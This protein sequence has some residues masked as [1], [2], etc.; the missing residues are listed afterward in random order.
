MTHSRQRRA[1]GPVAQ[2]PGLATRRRAPEQGAAVL[3]IVEGDDG[4]HG[5]AVGGHDGGGLLAGEGGSGLAGGEA[6]LIGARAVIQRSLVGP[7][8]GL[9]LR[10]LECVTLDHYPLHSRA[11]FSIEI[12]DEQ[13]GELVRADGAETEAY[14][15]A[16]RLPTVGDL[17][18]W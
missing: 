13:T 11:I 17:G 7:G 3:L 2:A 4:G 15:R 14:H 10:C 8:R 9:A 18:W 16:R 6:G 5:V 1:P 12:R